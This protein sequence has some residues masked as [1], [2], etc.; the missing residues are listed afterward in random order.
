MTKI[1]SFTCS[2]DIAVLPTIPVDAHPYRDDDL[3]DH[4]S[5][6]K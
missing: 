4:R 6:C 5:N 3:M 1:S 2:L